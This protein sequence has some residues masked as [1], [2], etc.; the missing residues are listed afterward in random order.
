MQ[1]IPNPAK[2]IPAIRTT[3]V[4]YQKDVSV[5]CKIIDAY[6]TYIILTA[7]LQIM[8]SVVIGTSYPYNSLLSG[9]CSCVGAFVLAVSLR[10]QIGNTNDR[11]FA[12]SPERAMADFIMG[13][14]VLHFIVITYL[15]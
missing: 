3:L 11:E 12:I 9:V 6:I 13:N 8:Y 4:K 2:I 10:L 5:H 15:G 1:Y 7:I 14:I